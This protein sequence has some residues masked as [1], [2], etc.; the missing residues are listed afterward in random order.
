MM[1][2]IHLAGEDD[3]DLYSGFNIENSTQQFADDESFQQGS[4]RLA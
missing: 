1:E 2:N 4:S 3:D